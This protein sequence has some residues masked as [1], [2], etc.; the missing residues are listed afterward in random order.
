MKKKRK[1]VTPTVGTYTNC[2]VGPQA[3]ILHLR[4][5][6][7]VIGAIVNIKAERHWITKRVLLCP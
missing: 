4:H 5:S 2:T 6:Q 1:A 7:R 3:D